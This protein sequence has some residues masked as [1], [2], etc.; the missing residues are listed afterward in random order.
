MQ[1]YE[2]DSRTVKS[3]YAT[4]A[5]VFP[6]VETWQVGAADLLLVAARA[7][8]RWDADALRAR[9]AREPYRQAL[10]VTWRATSLEQVLARYVAN[11]QFSARIAAQP[12]V[13]LNT[14]DRNVIEFGAARTVGRDRGFSIAQV[15]A[16][17]RA[18]AT[19][20]PQLAAGTVD[21]H[22][23]D[24]AI[25]DVGIAGE[26]RPEV[27][28]FLPPEARYRGDAL[29]RWHAG[30]YAQTVASWN[31]QPRPPQSPSELAAL[32]EALADAGDVAAVA[33]AK[34]LSAWFPIEA[35]AIL[36]RYHQR[37]G[38]TR[39]AAAALEAA[40]TAYRR[41]P[42]PLRPLLRRAIGLAVE[43]ARR[44]RHTAAAL[45]AALAEPFA[46]SNLDP[47]RLEARIAL[48]SLLGAPA[49]VEAFAALE[50]HVPWEGEFLA[51]RLACYT[52]ASHPALDR[53]A[54]ELEDFTGRRPE[55]F[56][57]GLVAVD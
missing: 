6:H 52:A 40:F 49:C 23:V 27:P 26:E 46:V 42:W 9:V 47:R 48:G 2:V 53:A 8:I 16:A 21:W 39:A 45:Y 1:A 44:D 19:H 33:L 38:D 14:D 5:A 3:T 7:P 4:L 43:V 22:A 50:P 24:E 18:L 30:Q 13:E 51:Q 29:A 37:N 28:Q 32:G 17:A 34:R 57:A 31:R 11:A 10:L 56:S 20:R 55:P 41:D 36:A 54:R 12:A 35:D 25:R 15:R